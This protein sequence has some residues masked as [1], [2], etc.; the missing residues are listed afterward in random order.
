[1][2]LFR[3]AIVTTA[4]TLGTFGLIMGLPSCSKK[5]K[6]NITCANNG[7]CVD[8]ACQCPAGYEGTDCSS[9]A[10]KKFKGMYNAIDECVITQR[11][12]ASLNYTLFIMDGPVNEPTKVI[13]KGL[14]NVNNATVELEGEVKGNVITIKSQMIEGLEYSGKIEYINQTNLKATFN[15]KDGVETL[16]SCFSALAKA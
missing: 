10:R 6:C 3:T 13:V 16:E 2:K 4:L 9:L 11:N 12:N 1:M 14:G 8:G 15:I 5:D 7:V